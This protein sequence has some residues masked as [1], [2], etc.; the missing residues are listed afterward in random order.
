LCLKKK[1]LTFLLS[2]DILREEV[3]EKNDSN[4]FFSDFVLDGTWGAY[5]QE[6]VLHAAFNNYKLFQ[7]DLPAYKK[8]L[9]YFLIQGADPNGVYAVSE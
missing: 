3:L 6:S 9:E 7:S 8:M 5:L 2:S 1:N 4:F